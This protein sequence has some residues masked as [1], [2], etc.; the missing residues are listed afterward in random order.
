MEDRYFMVQEKKEKMEDKMAST[1]EI[2]TVVFTCKQVIFYY[3]VNIL[4]TFCF[5]GIK[6]LALS[7]VV[8]NLLTFRF[9]IF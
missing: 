6:L 2:K 9:I 4:S 3:V 5:L 7:F 8:F 1:M